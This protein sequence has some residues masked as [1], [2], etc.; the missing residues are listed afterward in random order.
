MT[1]T[2]TTL[3]EA[4]CSYLNE[5]GTDIENN[6][7]PLKVMGLDY[8]IQSQGKRVLLFSDEDACCV[9]LIGDRYRIIT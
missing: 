5:G 1:P 4:F 3:I 6:L 7:K 9:T 2:Q 8:K